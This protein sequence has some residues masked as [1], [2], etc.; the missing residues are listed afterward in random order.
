MKSR[1]ID[2]SAS[3]Q[4]NLSKKLQK[5]Q[6]KL[7]EMYKEIEDM[8][9]MGV[10]GGGVVEVMLKGDK[11]PINIKVKKESEKELKNDFS[12]LI[13]LIIAAFNDG[14]KKIDEYTDKE[15]SKV[16]KGIPLPGIN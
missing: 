13:D 5:V 16:T 2:T 14:I 3:E 6:G 11:S 15:I 8:T 12:M 9:F 1:R 10:S 7:D 4:A